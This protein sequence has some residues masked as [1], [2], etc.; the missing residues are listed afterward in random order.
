MGGAGRSTNTRGGARSISFSP[1]LVGVVLIGPLA[2]PLCLEP[3]G[4]IQAKEFGLTLNVTDHNPPIDPRLPRFDRVRD[5]LG[6]AVP[7]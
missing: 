4:S 7:F 1:A 5:S 3:I 2:V 6:K